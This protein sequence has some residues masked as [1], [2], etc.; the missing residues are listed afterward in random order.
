M[1][2]EFLGVLN[3]QARASANAHPQMTER[4]GGILEVDPMIGGLLKGVAFLAGACLGA[5]SKLL[6]LCGQCH[7]V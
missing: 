7:V 3:P 1:N 6:S 2:R 5:A 4:L